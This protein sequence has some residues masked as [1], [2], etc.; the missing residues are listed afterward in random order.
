MGFQDS[1]YRW[2]AVLL[3]RKPFLMW[4]SIQRTSKGPPGGWV[5]PEYTRL[6]IYYMCVCV[7]NRLACIIHSMVCHSIN[8]S[9]HCVSVRRNDHL[10]ILYCWS[11]DRSSVASMG[12]ILVRMMDWS[13][14]IF[15]GQEDLALCHCLLIFPSEMSH[16]TRRN[17]R[18]G[19]MSPV[20]YKFEVCDRVTWTRVNNQEAKS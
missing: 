11:W 18:F 6:Y 7:F 14:R 16:Q 13:Q 20:W 4:R 15:E 5:V 19:S 8:T 3:L 1:R 10:S 2:M 9:C 17:F 12:S